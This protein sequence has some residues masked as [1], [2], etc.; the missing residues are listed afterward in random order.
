[1]LQLFNCRMRHV[2]I[3][4]CESLIKKCDVYYKIRRYTSQCSVICKTAKHLLIFSLDIDSINI[5]AQ[6]VTLLN[7]WYLA[8]Y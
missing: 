8:I 1:M 4:K 2:F 3:T 6:A 7:Q 5:F